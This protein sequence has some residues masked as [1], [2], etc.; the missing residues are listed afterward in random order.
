MKPDLHSQKAMSN[1]LSYG[2]VVLPT[3]GQNFLCQ[4][5]VSVYSAFRVSYLYELL[6]ETAP[7]VKPSPV[8][9]AARQNDSRPAVLCYSVTCVVN[10]ALLTNQPMITLL[11]TPVF[12]LHLYTDRLHFSVRL[13][14][15]YVHQGYTASTHRRITLFV[16]NRPNAAL[17]HTHIERG[18]GIELIKTRL[19]TEIF[20]AIY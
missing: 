1:L 13:N 20:I 19:F 4:F 5:S 18:W 10:S 2:T 6:T 15:R 16:R 12:I 11:Q 17:E 9:L 7:A 8:Y 14:H 3:Y